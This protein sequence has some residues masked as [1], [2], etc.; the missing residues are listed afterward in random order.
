MK[1]KHLLGLKDMDKSEII[2]I[3]DLSKKMKSV[4]LSDKKKTDDLKN[5]TVATL[6]YENST[7]TK[8][9]FESA[10]KALS[11]GTV[12]IAAQSSS[13]QKGETLLDTGWTL[14]ALMCDAIVMRHSMSGAPHLLSK[15]SKASILNGGDGTNEHPTQAL[16]DLLTIYQKHSSFKGLKI[17]ISGDIRHSRVARSNIFG[18]VKLGVDLTVVSPYT[19]LPKDVD[20]LGCKVSTDLDKAID[21]ANV[22]MGLRLQLERQASGLYPSGSEY[23]KF[24]GISNQRLKRADKNVLLLHPGPINRGLEISGEAADGDKSL[25]LEQ[26]TNGIAVRMA[27]L[28]MLIGN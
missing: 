15:H 9:S 22:V 23:H 4:L 14:D 28:K 13:V 1:R 27:A 18:M 2:E 19:L 10:A 7:R 5:K 17:V 20:Q 12:A 16:L 21:G 25:I 24:F 26:V 3:L 6:F 11:A 8:V